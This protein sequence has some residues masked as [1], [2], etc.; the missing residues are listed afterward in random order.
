M[1]RVNSE[2]YFRKNGYDKNISKPYI[3][4]VKDYDKDNDE[5][6]I[7]KSDNYLDINNFTK[8]SIHT[9]SFNTLHLKKKNNII[10][11][12]FYILLQL[13]YFDFYL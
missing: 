4:L 12:Q 8:E 10:I 7:Y 6:E 13:H 11:Q 9:N 5:N 1:D 3:E 2:L